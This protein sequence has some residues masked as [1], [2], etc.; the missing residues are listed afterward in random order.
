MVIVLPHRT[1]L[2]QQMLIAVNQQLVNAKDE[3]DLLQTICHTIVEQGGFALACIAIPDH[4]GKINFHAIAGKKAY[5]DDLSINIQEEENQG[6]LL[7]AWRQ[8]RVCYNQSFGR[9][10]VMSPWRNAAEKF[11]LRSSASLP[12][13]RRDKLW[14]ILS[15]YHRR[16][17]F[18][19]K[20]IK[21]LLEKLALDIS[22]GLEHFDLLA[23]HQHFLDRT[24]VGMAMVER[25][26]ILRI[27]QRFLELLQLAHESEAISRNIFTLI[28]GISSEKEIVPFLDSLAREGYLHFPHFVYTTSSGGT[29]YLDISISAI[30]ELAEHRVASVWTI[31][32]VTDMVTTHQKLEHAAMHDALTGLPNRRALEYYIAQK[33]EMEQDTPSSFY[34]AI[35]DIKYFKSI[36]DTYGH[37]VTDQILILI[38]QRLTTLLT[39]ED[40]LCRYG[41]Y[42]FIIVSE[43]DQYAPYLERL[44]QIQE[45]MNQPFSIHTLPT[46]PLSISMHLGVSHYPEH[47]YS[48]EQLLIHADAEPLFSSPL[49]SI[50]FPI[51]S[52]VEHFFEEIRHHPYANQIV[53]SLQD[54]EFDHLKTMTVHHLENILHP[55]TTDASIREFAYSLGEVHTLVG[56]GSDLISRSNE[57]YAKHIEHFLRTSSPTDCD[58]LWKILYQRLQLDLQVQLQAQES[59]I[60]TFFTAFQELYE[61]ENSG[62]RYEK[63]LS[64][65]GIL[66][67]MLYHL[68]FEHGFLVDRAYGL[69]KITIE[70]LQQVLS[71]SV[72]PDMTSELGQSILNETWFTSEIKSIASYAKWPTRHPLR[73]VLLA[74]GVRSITMIPLV[75]DHKNTIAVLALHGRFPHQFESSWFKIFA[76]ALQHIGRENWLDPSTQPIYPANPAYRKYR[77]HIYDG[78]LLLYVQPIVEIVSGSVVNYEILSRLR[79]EQGNIIP[80]ADFLPYLGEIELER[81]FRQGLEKGIHHFVTGTKSNPSIKLSLN[82]S[83]ST[84]QNEQLPLWILECLQRSSFPKER[85]VLEILETPGYNIAHLASYLQEL[86]NRELALAMDDFGSGDSNFMR[87][88]MFPFQIIKIDRGLWMSVSD[89]PL[90][91]LS[92]IYNLIQIAHDFGWSVIVEGLETLPYVEATYF[93]GAR[94]GQGYYYA[95]PQPIELLT[96]STHRF[97]E[98]TDVE[99]IKTKLGALAYLVRHR[100]DS[101]PTL[102]PTT[103]KLIIRFFE[104]KGWQNS[105][106][107]IHLQAMQH[108]DYDD[109]HY[110]FVMREIEQR[111]CLRGIE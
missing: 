93:L 21:V 97:A 25:A 94:Y 95:R 73:E 37:F 102:I 33:I 71:L 101:Q 78:N 35:L 48:I 96:T 4:E 44:T 58:R 43:D 26:D 1:N 72:D 27:N 46:M 74:E 77:Q 92:I 64:L 68:H 28:L 83:P 5:L 76:Q 91:T 79:D 22:N 110:E 47:G 63:L 17:K 45:A 69:Q 39:K 8:D 38:A 31:Q 55:D 98:L 103:V 59:T 53:E 13:H 6:P 81:L 10:P 62:Q 24:S 51:V 75:D 20:E 3:K 14:G 16:E 34:L 32:D 23:L 61:V 30:T 108:G 67:V 89:K 9:N 29:R 60:M 105:E 106:G 70:H 41:G 88:A 56:L 2:T 109:L 85:L 82:L 65:P 86:T 19:S 111:I 84:L 104:K 57:L 7:T 100:R 12:I 80:P 18:F 52:I 49:A 90:T 66:H 107:W 54:Q 11:Q 50:K 15:I 87:L 99:Q 40:F 36:L 42:D